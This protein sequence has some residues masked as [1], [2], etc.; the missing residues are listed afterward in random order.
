MSA[1]IAAVLEA[2][3]DWGFQMLE[4]RVT[5]TGPGCD[6]KHDDVGLSEPAEKLFRAHQAEEISKAMTG[7]PVELKTEPLTHPER[8]TDVLDRFNRDVAGGVLTLVHDQGLYRHLTF[9]PRGGNFCWFD[10]ITSPG[11]LTIRGDMGDYV[12]AREPDMLRDF[13]HRYVNA[14][15]WAE[16][17]IAQD[18][19]SPVRQYS[20]DKYRA[21]VLH[22]FWHA[23]EGYT[24]AEAR[25]LWEEIRINGPLSDYTDYLHLAGAMDALESFRAESVD[26]FRF[27]V[28]ST[29]D[30]EDWGHHYLWCC[31]A[32]LWAA[33]AYREH[34]RNKTLEGATA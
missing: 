25:A 7:A 30:F 8:H 17:V 24:P 26:G 21:Q 14:H 23:R 32:I 13:F 33:R 31:H 15:Y 18:V 10:I 4:N 5:C 3:P 16:K 22:D 20:E 19:H 28:D 1:T 11:Q 29:K 2:H 9:R 34:D 12:F 6:W 27:Q